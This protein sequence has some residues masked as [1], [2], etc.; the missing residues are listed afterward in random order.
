MTGASVLESSLGEQHSKV[1]QPEPYVRCAQEQP[2]PQLS[3]FVVYAL[4]NS[5]GHF[6]DTRN[7]TNHLSNQPNNQMRQCTVA[8]MV[9]P[10]DAV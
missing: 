10:N 1:A 7:P 5:C 3:A 9:T 4:E 2:S 8:G 6:L